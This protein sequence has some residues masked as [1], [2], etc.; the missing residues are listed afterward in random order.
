MSDFIIANTETNSSADN[1][2]TGSR[3][4][5][6]F[7]QDVAVISG[8]LQ[9]ANNTTTTPLSSGATYTGTGEQNNYPQVGVSLKTDNSGVLYFDF[10]NDGTNW[11]STFPVQGFSVASGI[12]EF[13]TAVKLGRYFRCR[14]VNDTEAQTYLRLY[15]YYGMNFVPS[16]AP[17]NQS[18]GLDSDAQNVRP[19]DFEDEVV[20]GRRSGVTA[21]AKFG[22]RSGLTSAGGEQTIWAT[23]GNFTP[24][25]SA[26]TFTITYNST[27]DGEGTTG[28]L[29]LYIQYIDANGLPA[30]L[31]HVLGSTGS[32]VT[33]I[34][35]LGINRVAVS[36]S[37]SANTNTNDISITATTATTTQSVIPALNGVS[38]Q[39]VYF[40][41]S[42][43]NAVAKFLWINV[44]KTSGGGTPRVTIKGYVYNRNV[45]T[46]FEVFRY[47]IDTNSEN[48]MILHEPIGFALSPTD[49]L[50]F[51][52]DTDTNNTIVNLRFSLNEYKIN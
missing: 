33:I 11:D 14:L 3:T 20:I 49:I 45:A 17:L 43:S 25:T 2:V 48:T 23:T 5:S 22:Y 18:L 12:H 21:F 52:A 30:V 26:E 16:V 44:N 34:T 10:S 7:A 41:G 8:L 51:V 50:E 31:N 46:R 40:V 1:R 24:L 9:S 39:C 35:G 47:T 6:K 42:N 36:S 4:D 37:G 38:Q 15:T 19:T 27:T 28:A 32:D 29:S 13:H